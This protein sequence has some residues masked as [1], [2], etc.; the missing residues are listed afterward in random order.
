MDE[1]V[2]K[3]SHIDVFNRPN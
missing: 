2:Y 1:H 3:I